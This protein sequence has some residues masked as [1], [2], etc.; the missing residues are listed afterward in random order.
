MAENKGCAR[1]R[2]LE[3][4]GSTVYALAGGLIPGLPL[5]NAYGIPTEVGCGAAP[6]PMV[7]PGQPGL[8]GMGGMG[9]GRRRRYRKSRKV[10]RS[11]KQRGGS[12]RIGLEP[13]MVGQ[14]Y[15]PNQY[16]TVVGM[17][18]ETCTPYNRNQAGGAALSPA[19]YPPTMDLTRDS[20]QAGY[21]ASK[22][23]YTNVPEIVSGT[24]VYMLRQDPLSGAA[25]SASCKQTGGLRRSHRRSRRSHKGRK[26]S[27]KS[28]RSTKKR[29]RK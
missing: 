4:G 22:A 19:P 12:Y 18:G 6:R 13:Q 17:R 24:P 2:V 26:T 23:V 21:E 8:P 20:Y 14:A 3:G 5:N 1:N 29:S 15:N 27:K 11:K 9:G 7:A 28:R 16:S 10:R 25:I